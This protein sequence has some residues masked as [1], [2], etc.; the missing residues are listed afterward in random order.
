MSS[1]AAPAAK[2]SNV[3]L[4]VSLCLNLILIGVIAM[5]LWRAHLMMMP[6]GAERPGMLA[7]QILMRLAP[8][9]ADKIRAIME[10]HRDR[11]IQLHQ[12]AMEARRAAHNVFQ[13]SDYNRQAFD[14]A[15]ERVHQADAALETERLKM[16]SEIIATLTPE[17]R[18]TVA[19]WSQERAMARHHHMGPGGF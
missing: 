5:G 1:D 15:L 9:E 14:N 3:A 12:T 2:R 19:Q 4:V 8:A 7:P 18:R 16:L 11:L 6:P 13:S 10:A 17:E